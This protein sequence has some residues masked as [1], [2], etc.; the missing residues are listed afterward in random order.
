MSNMTDRLGGAMRASLGVGTAAADEAQVPPAA[1]SNIYGGTRALTEGRIIPV[2]RIVA[3]PDQPRR[4]FEPEKLAELGLSLKRRGQLQPI[5]VREDKENDRF[6]I[7]AGERR[8]RAAKM[9]EIATLECIVVKRAMTDG[10]KLTLQL[11]ENC[12]REDLKPIEQAHAFRALMEQEGWTAELVAKELNLSP[13]TVGRALALLGL[14]GPVQELVETGSL[15]PST[16][17]E[18]RSIDSP[19]K[20][21]EVAAK[22]VRERKNRD[23]ALAEIRVHAPKRRVSGTQCAYDVSGGQVIVKGR[24]A[25]QDA[26]AKVRA[27]RDALAQAEA[28]GA[29]QGGASGEAA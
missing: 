1:G 8:W 3:D 13:Q 21:V 22:I 4:E 19:G 24:G 28:E 14:P 5:R 2:N 20:Q 9:M 16:A 17:A 10:E 12:V 26:G 15:P 29:G 6:V 23:Q 7:V 11:V 27:L 25:C 18:L